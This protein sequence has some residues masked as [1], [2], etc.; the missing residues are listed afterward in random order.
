M[1]IKCTI[2]GVS[3]LLSVNADKPLNKILQERLDTFSSNSA[4]RGAGCGNCVVLIDGQSVLS[5]LVPAFR[6]NNTSIMTIEGFKCTRPFHDIER[7]YRETGIMPCEQCY[8]SKTL[9]IEGL[10]NK[11]DINKPVGASLDTVF[12][13]REMSMNSCRCLEMRQ[14]EMVIRVAMINR[15]NRIVRK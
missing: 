15:R 12:I 6:L 11:L 5:C 3:Q 9:L 14:I 7:A 2:D 4:C 8:A 10:M 13:E 1:L